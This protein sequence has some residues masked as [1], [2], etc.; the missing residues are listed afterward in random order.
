MLVKNY[1][2]ELVRGVFEGNQTFKEGIPKGDVFIGVLDRINP[3]LKKV[4]LKDIN[5]QPVDLYDTLKNTAGNYGID[6][7][8]AVLKL[9]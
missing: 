8:N 6:D 5:G 2:A 4:Q 3:I 9:K 7:Y 1:V